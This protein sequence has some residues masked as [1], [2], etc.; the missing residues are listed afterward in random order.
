MRKQHLILPPCFLYKT[1]PKPFCCLIAWEEFISAA[2]TGNSALAT[3]KAGLQ[4]GLGLRVPLAVQQHQVSCLLLWIMCFSGALS[5]VPGLHQVEAIW[6]DLPSS[7][8]EQIP[9]IWETR[10]GLKSLLTMLDRT[11]MEYQRLLLEQRKQ[12][13]EKY[14]RRSKQMQ[15]RLVV[16]LKI[17]RRHSDTV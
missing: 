4:T 11:Y 5:S 7:E 16:S 3:G 17:N 2:V 9:K 8:Y 15:Y 6:D 10:V 13:R 14:K 1:W 12:G